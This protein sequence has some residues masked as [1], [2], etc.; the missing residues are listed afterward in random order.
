MHLDF[1][2]PKTIWLVYR[3]HVITSLR[4]SKR[5]CTG[6]HVLRW[7]SSQHA[8]AAAWHPARRGVLFMMGQANRM[9]IARQTKTRPRRRWHPAGSLFL[10]SATRPQRGARRSK[11][12]LTLSNNDLCALTVLFGLISAFTGLLYLLVTRT[13]LPLAASTIALYSYGGIIVAGAALTVLSAVYRFMRSLQISRVI[14]LLLGCS[15]FMSVVTVVL[16]ASRAKSYSDIL[17]VIVD[18]PNGGVINILLSTLLFLG[19]H[20]VSLLEEQ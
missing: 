2:Y 18:H 1:A 15:L 6:W 20:K 13:Q 14:V 4:R 5:G 7:Q 8:A 17:S 16:A 12:R 10:D 3:G 19:W 11:M 9:Q